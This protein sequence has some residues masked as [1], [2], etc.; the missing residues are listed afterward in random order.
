MATL[1]LALD[2]TPNCNHS[3]FYVALEKNWYEEVGIKLEILVPSA[4]YVKD[5]TPARRVVR[6]DADLC[7]APSESVI[8]CWTSDKIDTKP[9]VAV[10]AILQKNTSSIVSLPKSNINTAKDLDGKNYASYEGRFEMAIIQQMIKNGGGL[11]T[12]I[13]VVPPKLDCFDHVLRGESDAT[14]IFMG[15][16]GIM[17]KRRGIELSSISLEDTNV[18]YGYTPVLLASQNLCDVEDGALLRKFLQVTARGYSEASINPDFAA[19]CLYKMANHSTLHDLGLDFLKEAQRYLSD[20][21]YILNDDNIWG[22]MDDSR[23]EAFVSFLLEE[24]LLTN[25]DGSVIDR[26]TMEYRQIYTNKF[27]L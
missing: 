18:P 6:G 22:L 13:E 27:L 3:G 5:E 9:P 7:V 20:G 26:A 1:R 12:A 23:W 8:S 16:E 15:W 10:A 14:W 2:W 25:R 21:D 11:G 24:K 4:I 19:G 17:M